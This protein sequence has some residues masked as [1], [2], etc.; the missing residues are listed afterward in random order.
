MVSHHEALPELED[1]ACTHEMLRGL[2]RQRGHGPQ[3]G[4]YMANLGADFNSRLESERGRKTRTPWPKG[5]DDGVVQAG[6]W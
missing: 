4:Y 1:Y 6:T 5:E 3:K 2:L